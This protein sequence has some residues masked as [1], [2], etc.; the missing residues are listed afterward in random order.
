MS[1]SVD[2]AKLAFTSRTT[3]R[4]IVSFPVDHKSGK[5][6]AEGHGPGGRL[7]HSLGGRS[8]SREGCSLDRVG[9]PLLDNVDR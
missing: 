4:R 3:A 9:C 2:G 8:R 1:L 6:E 5:L 7:G